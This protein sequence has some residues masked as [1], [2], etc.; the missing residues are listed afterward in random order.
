MTPVAAWPPRQPVRRIGTG[1]LPAAKLQH[2]RTLRD[3]G[4]HTTAQIAELVGCS[5]A[6]L[7]RA[8]DDTAATAV[9]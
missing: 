8:L 5:R 1:I 2:A 7:D 3:G 9:G 4:V 6:T